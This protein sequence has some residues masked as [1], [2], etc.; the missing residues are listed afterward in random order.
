[1]R[2]LSGEARGVREE[3][4][5]TLKSG[6]GYL[7]RLVGVEHWDEQRFLRYMEALQ[8]AGESERPVCS[9]F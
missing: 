7:G 8:S 4:V 3:V 1:M 2:A 5:A 9:A 6:E